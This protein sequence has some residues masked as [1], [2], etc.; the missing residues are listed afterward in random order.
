VT[1]QE[2]I[3]ALQGIEDKTCRVVVR[4]YEAGVDEVAYFEEIN[5]K[6]NYYDAWYYG[7][8]EQVFAAEKLKDSVP[9]V[10]LIGAKVDG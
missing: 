1:V 2:L 5:I 3:E 10:Q 4:G 7:Q 9:A 6:L 8:H